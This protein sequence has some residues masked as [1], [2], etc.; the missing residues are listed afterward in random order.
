MVASV[1]IEASKMSSAAPRA[2]ILVVDDDVD[3]RETLA[4]VLEI[5]GYGVETAEHGRAALDMLGEGTSPSV[6]LLDLMMPVLDG[7][8]FL[9]ARAATPAIARIPVIVITAG[10]ISR[11]RLG[12]VEVLPKPV[13]LPRLLETIA[14]HCGVRPES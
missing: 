12:S 9:A 13:D 11:E 10:G 7:Y 3:I 1:T 2:S 8:G 6:I 4:E 5:E 14:K